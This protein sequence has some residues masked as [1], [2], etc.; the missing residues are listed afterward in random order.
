M[1][2]RLTKSVTVVSGPLQE[3]INNKGSNRDS[4]F[5]IFYAAFGCFVID[6]IRQFTQ[7][8]QISGWLICIIIKESSFLSHINTQRIR[9]DQDF[10]EYCGEGTEYKAEYAALADRS[11]HTVTH[12]HAGGSQQL[13]D[14]SFSFP[15]LPL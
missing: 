10:S 14:N 2:S 6:Y 11:P 1:P 12:L 13:K 9:M 5:F 3:T 4:F 8:L 7:I 15:A